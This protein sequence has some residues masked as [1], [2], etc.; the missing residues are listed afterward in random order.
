MTRP[1]VPVSRFRQR[2]LSTRTALQV[3]DE[4]QLEVLE[5][6]EQNASKVETGV[7]KH[8]E[9]VRPSLTCS[10]ALCLLITRILMLDVI[11]SI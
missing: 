1:V 11:F 4:D 3:I 8:E 6:D 7:E 5:G 9:S 2:K 10:V